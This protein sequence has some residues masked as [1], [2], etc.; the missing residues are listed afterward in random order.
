MWMK[1][2]SGVACSVALIFSSTVASA[3]TDKAK[4]VERLQD[5]QAVVT[6]IMAAPDKGIPSSILSG[7]TCLAVIPSFKKAAFVVGAQ[8]GQGVA[9]CRT[10]HGWSAPSFVQLAGGSFGFQIGGQA[11]DLII[12]AMNEQGLQ[13]MLKNKFK[14]GADAAASAGPVGRNAQA[15]T[16]WKMNAELLTYSR[17]KGL[18]AGIDLDGTVLSQNET[19]TRVMYGNAIPFET[20]LKGNQVTPEE[21]RPFVRTV[22]KYFVEAHA[23]NK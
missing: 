11:T 2:L 13:D 14:I 23:E 6:Q 7:A 16:D 9:T 1:Y 21:A 12:V 22:A 4:L 5:A 17:S 15:G 8:Y 19:D 20:I 3:A 10:S 18:F